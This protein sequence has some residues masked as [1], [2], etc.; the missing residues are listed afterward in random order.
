MVK[1]DKVKVISREYTEMYYGIAGAM[2]KV[3]Q[4]GIITEVYGN[5]IVIGG[6]SYSSKDLE[7]VEAKSLTLKNLQESMLESLVET[8]LPNKLPSGEF[9]IYWNNSHM[10]IGCQ[11]IPKKEAIKLADAIYKMYGN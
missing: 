1:G 7:I 10:E 2:L 8:H 3:G 6:Y 11:K 4:C 9:K 5:E